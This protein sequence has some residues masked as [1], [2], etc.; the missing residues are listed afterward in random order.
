MSLPQTR[1]GLESIGYKYDGE[2]H[3]RG[4][5]VLMLWFVT[6][7]LK[8]MPMTIIPGSEDQDPQLLECHFGR[9]PKAELFRKPKEKKGK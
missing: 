3:C 7:N 5:G 1:D 2:S 4:C 8:K 9:C 6:P